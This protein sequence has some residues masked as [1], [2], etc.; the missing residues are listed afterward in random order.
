MNCQHAGKP[1]TEAH[2]VLGVRS[3]CSCVCVLLIR[4]GRYRFEH[5]I[6]TNSRGCGTQISAAFDISSEGSESREQETTGGENEG[7]QPQSSGS[8]GTGGDTTG[9]SSDQ[10]G[11]DGKV[12]NGECVDSNV[13]FC[14][15]MQTSLGPYR[16][17]SCPSSRH[18]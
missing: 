3:L 11:V 10:M 9:T 1:K 17:V 12:E 15:V 13:E 2:V 16:S 14:S 18:A 7:V 8:R 5:I 4:M 6:T